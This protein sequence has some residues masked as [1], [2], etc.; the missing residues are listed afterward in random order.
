MRGP[1]EVMRRLLA[2]WLLGL[3]LLGA[4]GP[5]AALDPLRLD[6][7]FRYLELTPYAQPTGADGVLF[8]LQNSSSSPIELVLARAPL[9][10]LAVGLMLQPNS[11]P[12]LRLHASDAREFAAA[13]GR[14]DGLAF[15][16]PAGEVQS[17]FVPGVSAGEVLHLW[18]PAERAVYRNSRQTFHAG[19]L[20]M[21]SGLL[22]LAVMAVFYRRSRRA[23]YAVVMG[24]GLLVLLASLWMRDIVPD[25]PPFD[26]LL[27]YR[28]PLV[29]AA[30]GLGLVMSLLGHL[31]LVIRV[32]VNRNYWTRVIILAD[33]GLV[34]MGVFWVWEVSDPAFAGLLSSE[35]GDLALTLTCVTILLGAVFVPDRQPSSQASPPS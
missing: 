22:G 13:P 9:N 20:V 19:G 34:A 18:S 29:Q 21:L 7:G 27:S 6:S 24:G 16:V 3:G 32:A 30:F 4:A 15:S 31:N 23:A 1:A 5:A 26:A 33:I 17:F 2:V 12:A 28:L 10:D 25:T 11:R 35:L 8:A 14:G